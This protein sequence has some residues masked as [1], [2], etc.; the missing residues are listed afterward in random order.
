[1]LLATRNITQGDVRRFV[2]DYKDWLNKGYVL[3]AAT[4]TLALTA[5][6]D[7]SSTVAAPSFNDSFTAIYVYVTAGNLNE[8]FTVS[9]QVKDTNGQTVNDTLNFT[10]VSPSTG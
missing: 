8:A 1:M 2:V 9:L 5:G 4:A 3:D 10:V 6:G 7:A